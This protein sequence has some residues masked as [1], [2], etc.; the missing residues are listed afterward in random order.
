MLNDFEDDPSDLSAPPPSVFDHDEPG[1]TKCPETPSIQPN[2][3]ANQPTER[4][5]ATRTCALRFTA[6][7]PLDRVTIRLR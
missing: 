1:A 3:A 7:G 6:K 5:A 4:R 2:G